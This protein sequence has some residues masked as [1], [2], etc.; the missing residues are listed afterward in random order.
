MK[1]FLSLTVL[2]AALAVASITAFSGRQTLPENEPLVLTP[3][4]LQY[5]WNLDLLPRPL[6]VDPPDIQHW[7]INTVAL[8]GC[9]CPWQRLGGWTPPLWEPP[10]FVSVCGTVAGESCDITYTQIGSEK[11]NVISFDCTDYVYVRVQEHSTGS[12]LSIW[13]SP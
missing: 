12:I 2:V 8:G 1:K 9:Y 13:T 7:N 10:T 11:E 3:T 6:D 5:E 4:P